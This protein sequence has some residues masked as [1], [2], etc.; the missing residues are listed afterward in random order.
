MT[1]KLM[2]GLILCGLILAACTSTHPEEPPNKQQLIS[3]GQTVF[4]EQCA[5]CHQVDG[6]GWSHLY[7]KLAGNPIVTLHDAEPIID[8]VVYGQ[9]SMMGFREKIPGDDIA[10]VL[11]Y[12]RQAWGN[13][14]PPISPRQVH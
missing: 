4:L 10:A 12:I 6:S 14:A 8:T 5:E 3:R 9:G 2:L 13:D 7:P 11:S 1:R